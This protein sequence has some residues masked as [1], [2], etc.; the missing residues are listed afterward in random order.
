MFERAFFVGGIS[1]SDNDIEQEIQRKGLNAPRLNPEAIEDAIISER[2]HVF[3]GSCLTV[4]A[5]T[6]RNGFSVIGESASASQDNFDAAIGRET[7]RE[8]AKEKIWMLEGYLLRQRLHEQA[9]CSRPEGVERS[10]D[11]CT[12]KVLQRDIVIPAG[13]RFESVN[14]ETRRYVNGCYETTIGLSDDTAGHVMYG[15]DPSD[16]AMAGW[17]KDAE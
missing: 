16:P 1:M 7:A 5:L 3:D 13:T 10:S 8:K 2:Y 15:I 4:C 6:L 17:F 9:F 14:G 12:S 11:A